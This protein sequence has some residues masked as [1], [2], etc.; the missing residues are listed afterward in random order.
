[1]PIG[2]LGSL[3]F[4]TI[5]YI[6]M[7]A[8]LTGMMPYAQLGTAKPVATALEIY[9]SMVW[10]KTLGELAAMAGLS[11]VRLVIRMGQPHIFYLLA[12]NC[13]MQGSCGKVHPTTRTLYIV[14]TEHDS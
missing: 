9:P 5:I 13:L 2:I 6:A 4:C 14:P 11:P 3:V 1:M 10:R 7:S 12:K 8:A